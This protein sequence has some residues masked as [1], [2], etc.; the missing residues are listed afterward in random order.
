MRWLNLS[1]DN[2]GHFRLCKAIYLPQ[3]NRP[4]DE[5]R[6]DYRGWGPVAAGWTPDGDLFG[7]AAIPDI[8]TMQ[9][10][11]VVLD[12]APFFYVIYTRLADRDGDQMV[13][14][15]EREEAEWLEH[16]E[17]VAPTLPHLFRLLIEWD[18]VHHAPFSNSEPAAQLSHDF[19]G[20]L[21]MPVDIRGWFMAEVPA[22]PV[23]RYLLNDPDAKS[24]PE[25]DI[26]LSSEVRSWIESALGSFAP[27]GYADD[28]WIRTTPEP[29][30]MH[31]WS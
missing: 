28:L 31:P 20:I 9:T 1:V 18:V 22:M 10:Y 27:R 7:T 29:A 4:E 16:P 6:C 23:E 21:D 13:I 3:H 14:S 2:P 19:L 8:P 30:D 25:S 24:Y 15:P 17:T 5:T 11:E 12:A 26:V